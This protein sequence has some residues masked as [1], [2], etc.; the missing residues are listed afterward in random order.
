MGKFCFKA[1][2]LQGYAV[3]NNRISQLGEVI[4]IMKRTEDSLDSKQVLS[5][6]E[7]YSTALD[8]LDSYD[9]QNMQRPKGNE[10]IYV[11]T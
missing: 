1:V 4:R 8:L 9:H 5:V 3:N 6:I 10:A 2:H 7:R 11:L